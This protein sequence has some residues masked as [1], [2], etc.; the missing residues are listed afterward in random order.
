[1]RRNRLN[2]CLRDDEIESY[3]LQGEKSYDSYYS[4]DV[5]HIKNC[6]HCF[7]KYFEL[8]S[9]HE[10]LTYELEKPVSAQTKKMV[11]VICESP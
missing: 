3:V 8:R 2:R 10:I 5:Y 9:Y 6:Y 1:M 11:K 7:L 4:R